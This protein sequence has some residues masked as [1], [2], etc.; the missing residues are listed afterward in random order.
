MKRGVFLLTAALFLLVLVVA[1]SAQIPS[2][3]SLPREAR[4]RLDQFTHSV[5]L[6]EPMR[7]SKVVKATRPWAFT[8]STSVAVF[9]E[10]VDFGSDLVPTQTYSLNL[11]HLYY[12]PKELW[13]AVLGTG[14]PAIAVTMAPATHAVV[15]VG[16]HM[17]VYN[18]DWVVYPSPTNIS[19]S[20]LKSWLAKLGCEMTL[21]NINLTSP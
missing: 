5:Y 10:D 4:E 3:S 14:E 16:L 1:V 13:C 12:P 18:A 7:L 19:A 2:R 21:D 9:G 11:A 6:A 20:E 8:E 15:F 17:D